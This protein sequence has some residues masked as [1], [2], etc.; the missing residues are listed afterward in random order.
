M[1]GE[2]IRESSFRVSAW[3]EPL[4]SA[5]GAA[6]GGAV[7]RA[8]DVAARRQHQQTSPLQTSPRSPRSPQARGRRPPCLKGSTLVSCE[9]DGGPRRP[10]SALSRSPSANAARSPRSP[11]PKLPW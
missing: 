5:R 7:G 9:S 3:V 11:S 4:A 8:A 6:G 2:H 10:Q 1:G